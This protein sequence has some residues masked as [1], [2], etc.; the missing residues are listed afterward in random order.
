MQ[1]AAASAV[2]K[3]VQLQRGQ[4]AVVTEHIERIINDY[5]I[6]ENAGRVEVITRNKMTIDL[7]YEMQVAFRIRYRHRIP[8]ATGEVRRR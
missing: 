1:S 6:T 7:R 3:L 4:L 5:R 8:K 2:I